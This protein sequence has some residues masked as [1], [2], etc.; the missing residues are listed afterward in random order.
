MTN[1][2]ILTRSDVKPIKRND[3]RSKASQHVIRSVVGSIF[4]E[5][6]HCVQVNKE[7]G[8]NVNE[9]S[10]IYEKD[11]IDALLKARSKFYM[12]LD[13]GKLVSH[14]VEVDGHLFFNWNLLA[15]PNSPPASFVDYIK[16]FADDVDIGF[17][18]CVSVSGAFIQYQPMDL[19]I[20]IPPV[21]NSEE[22]KKE[23]TATLLGW[24][25]L[26]E[27]WWS[28]PANPAHLKESTISE[29]KKEAENI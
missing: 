12:A 1:P 19:W 2:V 27:K 10:P 11:D 18:M 17:P 29:I 20:Y 22:N 28:S 26:S 8:N 15:N 5:K 14:T 7:G 4:P 9:L 13:I 24:I 6:Q 3:A 23:V 25:S 21:S 16:N